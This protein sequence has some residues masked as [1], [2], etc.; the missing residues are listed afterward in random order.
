MSSRIPSHRL[1]IVILVPIERERKR[2]NKVKEKGIG[3][4]LP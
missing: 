4:E 3:I 2:V 1:P